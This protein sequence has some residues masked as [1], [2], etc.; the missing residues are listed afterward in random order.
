MDVLGFPIWQGN[1]TLTNQADISCTL[2]YIAM[3][4]F[5]NLAFLCVGFS[6]QQAVKEE[7]EQNKTK[8]LVYLSFQLSYF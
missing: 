4:V 8:E 5:T 3:D 1:Q 7:E 6:C 2:H